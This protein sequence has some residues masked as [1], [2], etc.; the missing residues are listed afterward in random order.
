[1]IQRPV[2]RAR[3]RLVLASLGRTVCGTLLIGWSVAAVAVAAGAVVPLQWDGTPIDAGTWNVAWIAGGTAAAILLAAV[4]VWWRAPTLDQ[5]A[6]EVDHQFGLR[7]RISSALRSD[8]G[9]AASEAL[10]QDAARHAESLEVSQRFPLQPGRIAWLPLAVLPVLVVLVGIGPADP[11]ASPDAVVVDSAEVQQVK[12]AAEALKK[13]M[14]QQRRRAE[15]SGLEDA[16]DL[17][18]K[19]ETQLDKMTSKPPGSRKDALIELNDIKEQIRKRQEQLG[20]PDKVRQALSQ[21][22]GLQGGPAEK[23]AEQIRRGDFGKAAEELRSLAEKIREGDLSDQEKQRLTK[24]AEQIAKKLKQAT[25]QHEQKKQQLREQIEAAKREGRSQDASRL[26]QQLNQAEAADAQMQQMGQMAE[27]MQQAAEAMQ[28]GQAGEAADQLQDLSDQLGEMQQSMSELEDLQDAMDDL[29]QSK[30]QMNC[31][32]CQ[33]GGCKA[34]QGSGQQGSGQGGFGQGEGDQPG[35]GMGRGAGQGDRPE[36]ES[37]T[38]TYDTQVRGDVQ[39]GRAI[40]AGFADGPN[41]KG[42]TREELKQVI[43]EAVR[44]A[45]DPMEDQVLPR[46]EGEQTRQYFDLLRGGE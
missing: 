35:N 11:T 14:A 41:R 10:L 19:L 4:L 36:S 22:K 2:V 37:D 46:D 5:V 12:A 32:Q 7:E 39:R 6:T 38:N 1:L 27:A 15:A 45:G 16:K 9:S 42:V 25:E 28:A 30:Q 44:E 43:D 8:N 13:Q 18:A 3:R 31:K 21:M 29:E 24:Q 20:S 34:C 23:V 33:G 40:I 26:Q 17:F